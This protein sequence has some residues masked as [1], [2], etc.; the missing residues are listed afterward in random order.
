MVSI[1]TCEQRITAIRNISLIHHRV[2][3]TIIHSHS[4]IHVLYNHHFESLNIWH[5]WP[6]PETPTH[7]PEIRI[8]GKFYSLNVQQYQ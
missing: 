1:I 4:A 6:D 3:Q 2:G 7:G 5:V 8:L